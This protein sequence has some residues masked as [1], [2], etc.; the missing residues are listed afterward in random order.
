MKKQKFH[1]LAY[2]WQPDNKKEIEAA[3]AGSSNITYESDPGTFRLKLDQEDFDV[4]LLGLQPENGSTSMMLR[5][6]RQNIP[7]TPVIVAS[8]SDQPDLIAEAMQ[9][10]A[11][12][13]ITDPYLPERIRCSVIKAVTS[14]SQTNELAYLRHTQDVVYNFNSVVAETPSFRQLVNNLRKFAAFDSTMLFTG[15][16]GTGKSFLAGTVHFNSPRREKPFIKVNCTNMPE[17]FLESELFGHEVGAFPG[18][19]KQRIGRLEQAD[20]GTL[21]LDE[22]GDIS[23]AVQAKLLRFLEEKSFERLGGNRTIY[24]DVRIIAAT[25]RNLAAKI[26]DGQFREDLYYRLNVLPVQ[27]PALKDRPNCIAPLA[28]KLLTRIAANVCKP[29]TGFTDEA[30]KLLTSYHWPGNILQLANAIERAV[31]LEEGELI[32]AFS[33]QSPGE[34]IPADPVRTDKIPELEDSERALVLRALRECNWVQK[35]AAQKLGISPRV[36][37]YKIQKFA[38]SHPRWRKHKGNR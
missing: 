25:N 19:D 27:L 26:S 11:C 36:M 23:P 16:T 8:P 10:G 3:L 31:I 21:F 14:R 24:L 4:I 20:G 37:N 32:S 6:I 13:F 12:D 1:I 9:E 7:S 30:L 29:I 5:T 18:A 33:L 38:I 35:K 28:Q 2:N 34:L 15:K 22:I 17:P